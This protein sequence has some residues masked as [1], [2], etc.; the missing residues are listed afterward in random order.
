MQ[1]RKMGVEHDGNITRHIY[2]TADYIRSFDLALLT[3][4]RCE[5]SDVFRG[6]SKVSLPLVNPGAAGEGTCV[7]VHPRLQGSVSL[8]KLSK[9]ALAM[10]Q[11]QQPP[12]NSSLPQSPGPWAA[13]LLRPFSGFR[14]VA[15]CLM[16][17]L[18]PESMGL[19]AVVVTLRYE[20]NC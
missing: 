9:P 6:Y 14:S 19:K 18:R 16:P 12:L 20:P 8:W 15:S 1:K 2:E 4:I 10:R 11:E 13:A 3:E 7:L 17:L 5:E